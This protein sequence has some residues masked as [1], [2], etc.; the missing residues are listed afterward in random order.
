MLDGFHPNPPSSNPTFGP[1]AQDKLE[2]SL[3]T[4]FQV[5]PG[6]TVF[7]LCSGNQ[8]PIHWFLFFSL[9]SQSLKQ[10]ADQVGLHPHQVCLL[11]PLLRSGKPV[12]FSRARYHRQPI[13]NDSMCCNMPNVSHLCVCHLLQQMSFCFLIFIFC[14]SACICV[15]ASLIGNEIPLDAA[16]RI[17]FALNSLYPFLSSFCNINVVKLYCMDLLDF[18]FF[19]VFCTFLLSLKFI[20]L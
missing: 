16:S 11:H 5:N 15:C 1:N 7:Q 6:S 18:L 2:L 10:V 8:P 20:K 4:P 12:T 17:F 13:V 19:H 3:E 9:L 14:A